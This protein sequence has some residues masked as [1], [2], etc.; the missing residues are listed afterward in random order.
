M[1]NIYQS[2]YT[3]AEIDEAVRRI[4]E[5]EGGTC[6][7]KHII[8]VDKLPTENIVEDAVYRIR[9]EKC[10]DV[11]VYDESGAYISI[12]LWAAALL[13]VPVRIFN[14]DSLDSVENPLPYPQG[15]YYCRADHKLYSYDD[16]KGDWDAAD[17][18][19]G[20]SLFDKPGWKVSMD[21]T[22]YTRSDKEEGP[23]DMVLAEA[24]LR[25]LCSEMY[26]DMIQY[27]TVSRIPYPED[28]DY[29]EI[30]STIQPTEDEGHKH[31]YYSTA[32]KDI[33]PA[34]GP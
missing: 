9:E 18:Q 32:N 28:E 24:G 7:G 33:V 34:P 25:I 10:Y 26:G 15:F 8:E 13:G 2:S 4:L 5:G 6:S 12:M 29:E 27:H 30:M 31:I 1:D 14:V 11:G 20:D 22:Y 19:D 23:I 3:G 16:E 17:G 21:Y